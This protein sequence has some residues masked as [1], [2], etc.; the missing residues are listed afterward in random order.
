MPWA[1]LVLF[2]VI[3][4]LL[5]LWWTRSPV[6]SEGQRTFLLANGTSFPQRTATAAPAAEALQV[7]E[8]LNEALPS[9]TATLEPEVIAD[10]NGMPSPVAIANSSPV[11]HKVK[12]GD[13]LIAIANLYKSTVKDIAEANGL[14]AD[15]LLQVGQE[16]LVPIAGPSGGP[17]PTATPGGGALMYSVQEGDTLFALALRY[18]SQVDWILQANKMKPGDFLRISQPL[19][20]PL[21]GN[22]P[23]PTATPLPPPSP[24]PTV[25]S[26]SFRAPELLAPADGSIVSSNDGIL[27]SWT[28]TG[29]LGE[30]QYYVVTL[31]RGEEKKPLATRWTKSTSWRLPFDYRAGYKA[32]VDFTW[33]VQIR[34][35]TPDAASEPLSQLSTSRRFT[36]Q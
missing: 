25:R 6:G 13:T 3:G 31:R 32:P 30:G 7:A 5:I 36:W 14:R 2:S 20:I 27:L 33:Q 21:S 19:L 28:S 11:R 16:L 10:P 18:G 15:G 29:T 4:G 8:L 17:G 22:T 34:S 24:T 1:D 35:G 9:P 12:Q 26:M 23:T